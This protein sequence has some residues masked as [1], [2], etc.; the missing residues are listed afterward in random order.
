ML[1]VIIA[2]GAEYT[3]QE[4][5]FSFVPQSCANTWQANSR[6][7]NGAPCGVAGLA[8]GACC[9][10]GFQCRVSG[11]RLMQAAPA[12]CLPATSLQVP[13]A[14][15]R[16]ALRAPLANASSPGGSSGSGFTA[17]ERFSPNPTEHP[18]A[19][20]PAGGAGGS[21]EQLEG[22]VAGGRFTRIKFQPPPAIARAADGRLLTA[23]GKEVRIRAVNWFGFN[24]GQTMV[25]GLYA[26]NFTQVGDFATIVYRLQLLGFN[27]VRL[28]FRFAD[29]NLPPK[30]LW[31]KPCSADSTAQVKGNLSNPT[32][33]YGA[34]DYAARSLPPQRALPQPS[35]ADSGLCNAYL[36][37]NASDPAGTLD[38]FLW[39]IQYLVG[40]G[41]YVIIDYHAAALSADAVVC[42]KVARFRDNWVA[43]FRSIVSLG[44]VWRNQLAG[45]L[46]LE[47]LNEPDILG[48]RWETSSSIVVNGVRRTFPKLQ[49]LYL[50][51][52]LALRAVS[53]LALFAVEGTGQATMPGVAYGN[54]FTVDPV[55]VA[56]YNLSNPSGFLAALT[57]Q[58]RDTLLP[59]TVIAPHVYG[60]NVTG[61]Q[62]PNC[63]D[64]SAC[65]TCGPALYKMLDASFGY[66]AGPGFR[67]S[68]AAA[69]VR[70]TVLPTE[71]G[72]SLLEA[73]D[74][75][76]LTDFTR[77][78]NNA[79]ASRG[80]HRTLHSWAWWAWNANAVSPPTGLVG[81][82][83]LAV[84]WAK[85]NILTVQRDPPNPYAAGDPGGWGLRPWFL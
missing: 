52:M 63:A 84:Q 32:A 27:G 45:R 68:P 74:V 26:G 8:E 17:Q 82:D 55:L 50:Q 29:L 79:G 31:V 70:L 4:Q 69:P 19:H 42:A 2:T 23:E 85:I 36:P 5:A 51:T 40:S 34:I 30:T 22:T 37:N 72:S 73:G 66:L 10:D 65:A 6:L 53:P 75:A 16:V 9:A 81:D 38:R 44:S 61:W 83:W 15:D 76:W 80:G 33:P 3:Q 39:V 43:L 14:L 56:R 41:F 62:P 47:L 67:A 1:N 28:P 13:P 78:A 46:F 11:P 20:A 24:N 35:A 59:R 71:F 18:A 54:G 48:F 60:P 25:D 77:W 7:P 64:C 21:A 12:A 49:R 58:H 57:G